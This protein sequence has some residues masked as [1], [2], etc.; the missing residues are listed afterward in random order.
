V[1]AGALVLAACGGDDDDAAGEATTDAAITTDATPTTAS[2]GTAPEPTAGS[3]PAGTDATTAPG[4]TTAGTEAAVPEP[5]PLDEVDRDATLRVAYGIS[6]SRLDPHRATIRND[7]TTLGPIYDRLVEFNPQGELVPMLASD[8]EFNEDATVLD[9]T[10]REGVTFHDGTPFNAEAVKANIERAKTLEGSTVA[11][12]L[13]G[14]SDVEVVDDTHVRLNLA[15]PDVSI[16]GILSDRAGMMISPAAFDQDLEAVAVGAGPFKLAEY[17]PGDVTVYERYD[18]YWDPDVALVKQLEIHVVPDANTRLNGLQTGQ[19]DLINP[20][21]SQYDQASALPGFKVTTSPGLFA[22]NM[23]MNRTRSE[24]D[25]VR[26]RQAVYHAIDRESI[27]QAILLGQCEVS[28][29]PFPDGYWAA[30]PDITSDRYAYDPDKARELLAEAGVPDGFSFTFMIPAALPPYDAIGEVIQAQ[31]AEVGITADLVLM[32]PAQMADRYYVA[33][34]TDAILG[35]LVGSADP[36]LYFGQYTLPDAFAN[37][38]GNST[39]KMEEL[40]RASISTSDEAERTEIIHQGV[41]E[42]VDQVFFLNIAFPKLITA[43]T[44]NVVGFVMPV[45]GN[46][47]FRGVGMLP[48]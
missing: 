41:E 37:P 43:T 35:G 6:V 40:Y 8:W 15:E 10:L 32:E 29:Q 1:A 47:Q 7:L 36:S 33:K 13:A 2:D 44:E 38:S 48:D 19:F 46:P 25:D 3:E 17:R 34:E 18:D 12:D 16:L 5:A 42:V 20:T 28:V 22:I 31:L 26:V 23:G 14:V 21:A 9:M 27:C 30:N 24:F 45:S 4:G 39:D 11:P